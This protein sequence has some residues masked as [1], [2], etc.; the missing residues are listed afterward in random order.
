MEE[1][2][3][4]DIESQI[5]LMKSLTLTTGG[6]HEWQLLQLKHYLAF[7]LD[8]QF[9]KASIG[10]DH[11]DHWITFYVTLSKGHKLPPKKEILQK[12]NVVELWVK[13]LLWDTMKIKIIRGKTEI[14][15]SEEI[16]KIS[17]KI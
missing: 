12:C 7:A 16:N 10:Y 9:S 17:K 6:L 4:I 8:R 5:V 14:Y 3:N 13:R 15:S 11:K 2:E 1:P